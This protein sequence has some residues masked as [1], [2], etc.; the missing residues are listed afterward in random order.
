MLQIIFASCV[1]EDACE[2]IDGHFWAGMVMTVVASER[3]GIREVH[4]DGCTTRKDKY[5]LV[6]Q[7]AIFA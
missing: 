1:G 5:A 4:A 3:L 6:D 7:G 2:F